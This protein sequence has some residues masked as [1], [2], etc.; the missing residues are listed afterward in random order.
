MLTVT[1]QRIDADAASNSKKMAELFDFGELGGGGLGGLEAEGVKAGGDDVGDGGA[2]E[3]FFVGR[4]DI[5]WGVG[6]TGGAEHLL[7][8]VLVAVPMFAFLDIAAG[9]L[10]VFRGVFEAGK[11]SFPLLLLGDVEE[12][13]DDGDVLAVE[14]AFEGI[15]FIE[16]DGPE[17]IE[18]LASEA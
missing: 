15:D 6:G 8:G 17:L 12:D 7:V 10:E 4:N 2:G 1:A 11:E 5:P 14:L 16:A 3:P 18:R 9:E 13:F